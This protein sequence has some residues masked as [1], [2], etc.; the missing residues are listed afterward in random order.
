MRLTA[1]F[2]YLPLLILAA[3]A[4]ATIPSRR[5]PVSPQH[6]N[7]WKLEARA[8]ALEAARTAKASSLV[9]QDST[10]GFAHEPEPLH[11]PK[12]PEFPE[13][14][15]E[16]PVDHT[17]PSYGTFK[18]RYWVNTRHYVPGSGGP[19]IV[20]DGGE[21]SGEDRLPFLDTGIV[22]I[23]TNA[24]G[25]VGVVLEHRYYGTSIPVPDFST[26]N[27]RWLNN[28]QAAADSANF[29]SHVKFEGIDEDLTAP[30]TPWI[31]YGGSYAGARA[32]HMKILYPDLVFGAIAS[33]GVT[34]A[35]LSNWEYYEVIREAADPACS[36]HLENAI[37]T[38]D[39]LLQF[40]VLK[41]VVKALFGLHELKHDDDFVSVLEGPLGAWQSKNWDPAVGSTS[42]D[43]F[44]ES[45]S[46]P[47][48]APHIGALPIGHEDRLV[49][50]LDD[51]KIDFSVLNFAQWVREN[52]VKPC[53]ELNT[54]VEEC[55]GTYDD[56][57][58]T[59]TSLTQ[60][61]RLWQFQV[62]TEW[63]YFSTAPPD[64]N[65][66]RIVS[67]L[68]TMDYATKLC[69]Q[70]YPPGKHFTVPA[71]PDISVVNVLGDFAIAADRLAII[72]GEVDPW[73]PCTPHSEYAK[74]RK[75]TMLRPFKLIPN[76]VHHYDEYGLR[77]INDEP[78]EIKQIHYEMIEF[79][80][81]WLQ[82]FKA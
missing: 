15:F 18:Q 29:M 34:H 27:L 54:T 1:P 69:R 40:P 36:A 82:D 20:L 9:L 42:F 57:Q 44:C 16:Q 49:T 80:R 77:D 53:L 22:E 35:V 67:K 47:V 45:L 19:V 76:G 21:T 58:Y 38:V 12:Y 13:Q 33:S 55:F 60:E 10:N 72:D 43:D 24:T 62:C 70:A 65:H 4:S 17:D 2:A 11:T 59:N 41:D 56:T 23:L 6:V 25:G 79:V 28:D 52:A 74:D 75:D 46:K 81:E 37:T 14:F 64:P 39:T 3:I 68:L 71:Q 61:W 32:A 26:D 30:R 63:G 31:Y 7:L 78:P 8:K 5:G 50:L 51:Q 66:P 73:R 48:G